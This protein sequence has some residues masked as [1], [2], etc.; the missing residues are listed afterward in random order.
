MTPADRARGR[1]GAPGQTHPVQLPPEVGLTLCHTRAMLSSMAQ[2][3][4]PISDQVRAAIDE[5]GISRR[6]IC[7]EIEFDEAS[8]SKF[9]SRQRGLSME[10]LDRLGLLLGISLRPVKPAKR[11]KGT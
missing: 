4:V 1:L 3:H 10:V 11:A 9:M 8:M 5:S 7:A 6:R 2:K